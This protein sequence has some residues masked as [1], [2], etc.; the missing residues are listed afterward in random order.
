MISIVHITT[1]HPRNDTRI[2][3]KECKS[4]SKH[5]DVSLIVA[6]GKGN[7]KVDGINIIDIGLRQSSRI[8]RIHID[9][10]K[11]F[12]KA[13]KINAFIYHFHDP[14][15]IKIGL[16]LKKAGKK[17][18]YDIHEDVSVQILLKQWIPKL[19]RKLISISFKKYENSACKKFDYL[20]VPQNK[21]KNEFSLINNHCELIA[22]YPRM[23]GDSYPVQLNK[24]NII[25]VGG[26][27]E[28]R[29]IFNML[30]L[31][32]DL[33]PDYQLTLIGK[34]SY[35]NTFLKAEK[36]PGWNKVNFLGYLNFNEIGSYYRK[37]S[38]G[39]ILFNNV[40]QYYMANAVKSF[41]YMMHGITI[42]MPDFGEWINF[43]EKSK[44]GFNVNTMN[45]KVIAGI[46]SGLSSDTLNNFSKHNR[47][48]VEINY[49]WSTEE[50]KLV[51]IYKKL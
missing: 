14:E 3:H 31:I 48:F 21:M 47:E 41:E 42:I 34:F 16:K 12:K 30:N 11:A 27:T 9:S 38:I 8:K 17:V 28:D 35:Q 13:I 36:H 40:G 23:I 32:Y 39:L 51:D 7:E 26:L 24:K 33:G 45:S 44:C 37:N 49:N 29:G 10:E 20:F 15:L 2:F 6:D 18:I 19:F 25:Y 1:V 43:N 46:I 50:L 22:N 4:L 5:Y